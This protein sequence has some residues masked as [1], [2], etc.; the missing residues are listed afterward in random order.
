[1]HQHQLKEKISPD[2]ENTNKAQVIFINFLAQIW[3]SFFTRNYWSALQLNINYTIPCFALVGALQCSVA[4][5]SASRSSNI[6]IKI[7]TPY[8]SR[9]AATDMDKHITSKTH[10]KEQETNVLW[11]FYYIQ[12]Y[13]DCDRT[14][15]D[16]TI[17]INAEKTH[18]FIQRLQQRECKH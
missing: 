7:W 5:N 1:M 4:S 18:N 14:S 12:N 13:N 6:K 15:G 2:F 9:E 16:K 8:L 10:V 11:I 3:V 17:K